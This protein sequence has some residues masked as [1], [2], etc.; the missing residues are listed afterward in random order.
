[1]ISRKSKDPLHAKAGFV[2]LEPYTCRIRRR[3]G[4]GNRRYPGISVS[5]NTLSLTP[6]RYSFFPSFAFVSREINMPTADD[7]DMIDVERSEH[8]LCASAHVWL[9]QCNSSMNDVI[10]KTNSSFFTVLFAFFIVFLFIYI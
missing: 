8:D 2:I 10:L 4:P 5:G 6:S 3:S 7:I 1:M 9:F